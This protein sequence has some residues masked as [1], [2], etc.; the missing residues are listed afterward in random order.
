MNRIENRLLR[1]VSVIT[2]VCL[3]AVPVYAA[4]AEEPAGDELRLRAE[5]PFEK[6]SFWFICTSNYHMGLHPSE[7]QVDQ[8][9]D[10]PIKLIFP[11]WQRPETFKDWMDD[12][13]VWDLSAGYGRDINEKWSWSIY[14]GGGAGTVGN[15]DDYFF[16]G[17]PLRVNADFTRRSLLA[18][19]SIVWHPIGK[20]A[21]TRRGIIASLKATK[22]MLEMNAG[23][24]MQ[25]SIADV[26]FTLPL[27]GD[28]LHSKQDDTYHLAWASPR[29]GIEIP[30]T[31]RISFNMLAGWLFFRPL[32]GEYNGWMLEFYIRRRF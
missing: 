32:D 3:A 29:A 15:S 23:Y 19:A 6:S 27:F 16:L 1:L 2:L 10:G 30:L 31:K 12:Y 28:V 22:P 4:Q 11:R 5:A 14:A 13:K 8:M 25:T 24:T 9:L 7:R 20:P 17:M 26:T 21:K 18:G